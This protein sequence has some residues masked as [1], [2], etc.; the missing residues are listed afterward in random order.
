[1]SNNQPIMRTFADALSILEGG[2]LSQDLTE[3]QREIIA[4]INNAVAEGAKRGK[5]SLTL[6]L[7]YTYDGDFIEIQ[8]DVKTTI[9]KEKRGR[10]VL[11]TTPDNNLCRNDPRQNEMF[12]E[13][14]EPRVVKS[15]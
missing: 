4:A 10:S 3:Q 12:G 8:A 5:G 15:V 11:W 6:K 14:G 9:P 13:P 2:A 1:M 7:D